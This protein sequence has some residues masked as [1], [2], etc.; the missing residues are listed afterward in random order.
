MSAVHA[1]TITTVPA[2]PEQTG[3]A[4]VPV[5][6]IWMLVALM[7]ALAFMGVWLI[8]R[9]TAPRA[10]KTVLGLMVAA[11]LVTVGGYNP[12]VSAQQLL[13][14]LSFTQSG[15]ETLNV[16]IL[17]TPS[18]G[19]P[20]DFTPVQFTNTTQT[21]LKI[22]SITPPAS[23]AVCFPAGVPASLPSTPLPSGATPCTGNLELAHGTSCV[24]NVASMCAQLASTISVSPSQATFNVH[25]TT[26]LTVTTN[27]NSPQAALHPAL[28]VPSGSH[29]SVLSSTCGPSLAP[30]A[31]CSLTLTASAAE[32]PTTLTVAGS[33]SNAAQVVLTAQALPTISVSPSALTF[34]QTQTGSVTVTVDS[35]ATVSA[36]N[37]VP[38]IPLGSQ[39]AVQSSTCGASVAPG[40]SCVI[41]FTNPSIEGP[42]NVQMAG[43]NTNSVTL[44]VTTQAIPP[45]VIN[46]SPSSL[47][48]VMNQ[49]AS[50]TVT[51]D[52][53]A[54]MSAQNIAAIVPLGSNISVQSMTCGASLAPGA[55]CSI[56]FTSSVMEGPTSVNV[57]GSNTSVASVAVTVTPDMPTLTSTTRAMCNSTDA[58]ARFIKLTGTQ[59]ATASS[60]MLGAV[61][62]PSITI[63]SD[64]EILAA[65]PSG[66]SGGAQAIT[67]TTNAGTSAP[68]TKTFDAPAVAQFCAGDTT[69]ESFGVFNIFGTSQT[70]SVTGLCLLCGVVNPNNPIS[71]NITTDYSQFAITV[72]LLGVSVQQALIGPAPVPASPNVRRAGVIVSDDT[73]DGLTAQDAVLIDLSLYDGS[74]LAASPTASQLTL[75]SMPELTSGQ[76]Q[77]MLVFDVPA[78]VAFD[79]ILVTL[80]SINVGGIQGLRVYGAVIEQGVN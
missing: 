5:D 53:A 23:A 61:P 63:V 80:T 39:L 54:P 73:S 33:N 76:T 43:S 34:M 72:G 27:A 26:T 14:L 49:S 46:V 74:D 18:T 16:P 31:S 55:S 75:L 25:G 68:L 60:V 69:P 37:V 40:A 7:L 52:P 44:A 36:E 35:A 65:L 56:T 11:G 38:V 17:R 6:G 48:F 77:K 2:S 19:L 57:A 51:V 8:R 28:L 62:S 50:V 3:I 24:V 66:W 12:S 41:T 42:T 32:G 45:T 20:V 21:K 10:L 59:L 78:N 13:S 4:A 71:H 58:G 64:T 67:V 22:S 9:D 70:N 1:Q 29:I 30:G 47:N 15:G 79:R